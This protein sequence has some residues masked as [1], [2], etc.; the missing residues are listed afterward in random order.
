MIHALILSVSQLRTPCNVEPFNVAEVVTALD[1]MHTS[2]YAAG[3]LL[4][5][6]PRL[7]VHS[8]RTS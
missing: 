1:W 7:E 4:M 8:S 2:I 5:S 3:S 6:P